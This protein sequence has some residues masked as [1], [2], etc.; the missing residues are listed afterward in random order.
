MT[1]TEHHLPTTGADSLLAL[2][3]RL[4]P[5]V[6]DISFGST[7]VTNAGMHH[8]RDMPRLKAVFCEGTDIDDRGFAALADLKQ[9]ESLWAGVTGLGNDGARVLAGLPNLR[10]IRVSNTRIDDAGSD[11]Q[12]IHVRPFANV[13]GLEHVQV[14]TRMV[15]GNRP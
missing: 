12:T 3:K 6:E 13:R 10:Y 9:L 7:D 8:L 5:D 15:N 4:F 11:T 14:L 2:V 1:A